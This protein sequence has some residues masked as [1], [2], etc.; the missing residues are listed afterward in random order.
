MRRFLWAAQR[1]CP[2]CGSRG[3]FNSWS[4]ISDACP[5]CSHRFER[6]EGYW[7]GAIAI[8]TV[9]TISLFIVVF[10]A[11]TVAFWPDPPW[12]TIS[13]VTIATNLLFPI[14]FYPYSKTLWVALE[15]G[16]HPITPP[17]PPAES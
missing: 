1:R 12:S 11:M 4:A 8:N 10:V 2:I 13:V 14:A 9:T 6:H 15:V 5:R 16:M 3:I 7:L 17:T